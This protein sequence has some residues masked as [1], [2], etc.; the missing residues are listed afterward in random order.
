MFLSFINWIKSSPAT[1]WFAGILVFLC[2]GYYLLEW[3][4]GRN[5]MADF[6]VYYD[7]AN[8]LI[9]GEQVYGKSFGVSSGFFKYSPFAAMVFVPLAVLPYGIAS[10]IFYT[11]IVFSILWFTYALV[12][13]LSAWRQIN[14]DKNIGWILGFSLLFMADH[15][16]RELHLGNVNLFLLIVSFI[17]YETIQAN[18]KW[19]AGILFALLLLFKPHF[20]ILAPYFIWRKEWKVLL[21]TIASVVIGLIIPAAFLGWNKNFILHNQWITAIRDHNVELADSPN[22]IYGIFNHTFF[23]ANSNML[24]VLILLAS[25]AGLFLLL[26]LRNRK[27]VS[28][29]G[30]DFIEFFVLVALIPNLAHT[31]TEH[32][33]WTWPLIFYTVARLIESRLQNKIAIVLMALAFIPYCVNSPDIVGRDL[34]HLFDEGLLGVANLVI[35]G[36]SVFLWLNSATRNEVVVK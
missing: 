19:T 33:M 11:L 1:K 24:L 32:F 16:E 15:L 29:K 23:G 35:I 34:Q 18:K 28:Q 5:Q 10:I 13:R 31:D 25:V 3:N 9:D 17:L 36:V 2:A 22:T 12:S 7:A 4:N 14:I 26:M 30:Y 6:R 8:S 20:F 27:N 21:S